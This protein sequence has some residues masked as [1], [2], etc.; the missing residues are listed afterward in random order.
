MDGK[1]MRRLREDEALVLLLFRGAK[2][3]SSLRSRAAGQGKG[4]QPTSVGFAS[5]ER[6]PKEGSQGREGAGRNGEEGGK[7]E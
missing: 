7:R 6:E 4:E 1:E 3:R 5:R 2:K